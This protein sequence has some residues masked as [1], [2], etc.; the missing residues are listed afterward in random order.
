MGEDMTVTFETV[1]FCGIAVERVVTRSQEELVAYI[2][3][4]ASYYWIPDPKPRP[5]G[6]ARPCGNRAS[7]IL[8]L[9]LAGRITTEEAGILYH[10]VDWSKVPAWR[11]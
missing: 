3:D 2:C 8:E 10:E 4:A 6:R 5:L 11:P 1:N 9:L 7:Q